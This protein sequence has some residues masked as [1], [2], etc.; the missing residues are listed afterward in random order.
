MTS[1]QLAE[2]FQPKTRTDEIRD[3][4]QGS[5]E[6]GEER[7]DPAQP[8]Y[9]PTTF[10]ADHIIPL[11][12]I[13]DLRGF[14]DLTYEQMLDIVNLSANFW[15]MGP[16]TNAST[17]SKPLEA[18]PGHPAFAPITPETRAMLRRISNEAL[19]AVTDAIDDFLDGA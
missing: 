8:D 1:Q 5:Y 4:V 15:G 16:R 18:W 2:H 7:P 17:G 11:R 12:R 3:L 10:Q 13:V 6:R 19:D 9:R 14:R